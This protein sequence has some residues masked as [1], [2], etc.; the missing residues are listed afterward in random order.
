MTIDWVV[1][2]KEHKKV[3]L[4]A[5]TLQEGKTFTDIDQWI[6]AD[7]PP[8]ITIIGFAETPPDSRTRMTFQVTDKPVVFVC[9]YSPPDK[10]FGTLG[11][12]AVEGA[13][14]TQPPLPTITPHAAPPVPTN[15]KPVIIDTDMGADDWMALLYLLQRPELSIQAITV[16]GTGLSHCGPGIRHA[17]GLVA[18]AGHAPLPIAC[19]R[20][21]PLAGNHTFPEGWRT[22]ADTLMSTSIE[23]PEGQ[24]TASGETAVELLS[25][26]IQASPS[27][28]TVL[29]LGPLTNLAELF[30]AEPSVKDKIEALTIMGGAVHVPGNLGAEMRGDNQ[31]AESNIYIDPKAANIVFASG[32]PL[33]LVPL[34]A[35][36]QVPIT[37][38][39]Y[40]QLEASQLT[41]EAR[42]IYDLFT[43]EQ[44]YFQSS[45]YFFWDPLAAALLTDESL[46]TYEQAAICVVEAE[47]STSGQ[48]AI[49]AG[50]PE[51]R[52]AV[53]ADAL[54]FEQGGVDTMN[55]S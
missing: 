41:P 30:Q 42:W 8:W 27:K 6:F 35:T 43:K 5:L 11:P 48:T 19:G 50:C 31:A 29:V 18:V 32:V 14:A 16:S 2:E 25:A 22:A 26:V 17:Q 55:N 52:V 33:T 44:G 47:G 34:D 21:T 36:N 15:P 53:T 1:T 45:F 24:N 13:V 54:R 10:K 12:V 20:E 23:L 37:P 49:Q 40:R 39:F 46:A 7:P 4:A 3:G 51:L 38:E 28:V 9:F